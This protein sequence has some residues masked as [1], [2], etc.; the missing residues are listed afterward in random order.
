MGLADDAYNTKP[1]LKFSVQ[2]L[3]A[4]ILIATGTYIH[5]FGNIYLDYFITLAWVVGIMNSINMLDN[6]DGVATLVSIIIIGTGLS[7]QYLNHDFDHIYILILSGVMGAL[8]GFLFFNW[9]PSRMF[10]GDT[11]S[12]FLGLILSSMAIICFWNAPDAA[13]KAI[14]TK[15]ILITTLIFIIPLC[16]TAIVVFNRIMRGRSPFIGG[17]DHTTHNLFFLGITE[18]RIAVLFSLVTL[19]SASMCLLIRNIED[20]S[21]LHITLFSAWFLLIFFILFYI[22][23][24][25]NGS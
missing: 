1:L 11:G 8:I 20:W 19:I 9:H 25:K 14:Q 5:L 15:Q 22:V 10:M 21:F 4:I 3:C 12:Q 17:K 2:V 7:I 13:G 24:K 6:M 18:K 16:D 23:K